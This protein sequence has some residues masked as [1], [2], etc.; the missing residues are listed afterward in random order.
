MDNLQHFQDIYS[1]FATNFKI[2][3]CTPDFTL[4]IKTRVDLKIC[5]TEN[6]KKFEKYI[7]YHKSKKRMEFKSE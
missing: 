5:V 6:P 1:D 4:F 3:Y 7:N 2:T